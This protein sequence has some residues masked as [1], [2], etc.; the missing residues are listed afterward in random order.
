MHVLTATRPW[1]HAD[2]AENDS[3]VVHR[4]TARIPFDLPIHPRARA[5]IKRRLADLSPDVVHIH[6]GAVS[7]FAWAG[8]NASHDNSLPSVTTVHSMWAPWTKLIYRILKLVNQWQRKT[9]LSAVSTAAAGPVQR[10]SGKS[11]HITPNGV[12]VSMWADGLEARDVHRPITLVSATRFAPRKRVMPL[13]ELIKK[14]HAQCGADA[15]HLVIAGNGPQFNAAQEFVNRHQLQNVVQFAGRIDRIQL[16]QLF[17]RSDAF[18]Q[19]SELESFGIAA[20]EARAVGI[21]VFGRSGNGFSE[22]VEHGATG[23]LEASD[24]AVAARVI[25]VVQNPDLLRRL[26]QQ[27]ASTPPVQDW[28]FAMSAVSACYAH[29]QSDL[30]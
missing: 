17:E 25:E 22:F 12:D 3:V 29:S 4:L 7:Q 23:F 2:A 30:R 15:V 14:V 21:P 6:M 26:K 9:H 13:L 10:T 8:I 20:I 11:V 18:I 1:P 19:L 28:H 5:V 27:A 16:K 24:A